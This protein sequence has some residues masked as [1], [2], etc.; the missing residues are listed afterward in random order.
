MQLHYAVWFPRRPAEN[1]PDLYA[2][3]FDGLIWRVSLDERGGVLAFDSIHSCGCYHKLYPVA[4][5]AL[6]RPLDEREEQPQRFPLLPAGSERPI[7]VVQ[8]SN[9]FIRHAGDWVP[10]QVERLPL[11]GLPYGQLYRLPIEDGSRSISL[12][13]ARGLVPGS[14][15]LE[16]FL[17]W[18]MGIA[19]PGAMRSRGVQAV[20]FTGRRHFDEPRLLEQFFWVRPPQ[21]ASGRKENAANTDRTR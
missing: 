16:R 12:F 7:V 8:S 20:R 11:P 15:R 18:P 9:H 21:A 17:L 4:G 19:S 14:E 5:G 6:L 2:G 10:A 3:R 13:D 1:R